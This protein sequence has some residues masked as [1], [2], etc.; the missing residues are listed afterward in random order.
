[1]PARA[2]ASQHA[3]ALRWLPVVAAIVVACASDAVPSAPPPAN[4]PTSAALEQHGLRVTLALEAPPLQI[5]R[6]H[7]ATV[8][9]ENRG[10]GLAALGS[11]DCGFVTDVSY[12]LGGDWNAVGVTQ[13]GIAAEFKALA[14]RGETTAAAGTRHVLTPELFVGVESY[15]CGGALVPRFVLAGEVLEER[16]QWTAGPATTAGPIELTASLDFLGRVTRREE[17]EVRR[18]EVGLGSAIEGGPAVQRVGPVDAIDAA[19]A[20]AAFS[21]FLASAPRNSWAGPTLALDDDGRVWRVGLFV[22]R[23]PS[24]PPARGEVAVDARTGLVVG[25]LFDR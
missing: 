10:P 19:L 2:A 7:V 22:D 25:R 5:G 24:A 12:A 9:V 4:V 14:L 18:I 23:G 13:V 17:M 11:N 21:V 16:S 20:D 1:M 8:T 6:P 15:G 3:V